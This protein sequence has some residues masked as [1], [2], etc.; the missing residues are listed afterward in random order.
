LGEVGDLALLNRPGQRLHRA[1]DVVDQKLLLS[2]AHQ[3]QKIVPAC[4]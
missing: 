1:H 2:R 3:P 4:L